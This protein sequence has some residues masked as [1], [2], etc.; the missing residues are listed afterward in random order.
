VGLLQARCRLLA[1]TFGVLAR[2]L[3]GAAG[4]SSRTA[5]G[6]CP[7]RRARALAQH[8]TPRHRSDGH[9]RRSLEDASMA[10]SDFNRLDQASALRKASFARRLGKGQIRS[11]SIERKFPGQGC[12]GTQTKS[13]AALARLESVSRNCAVLASLRGRRRTFL[14]VG[15][16]PVGGGRRTSAFRP[17][18]NIRFW[19]NT[20]EP[21]PAEIAVNRARGVAASA[22][23]ASKAVVPLPANFGR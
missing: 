1:C 7:P 23:F 15:T 5:R 17:Q 13:L 11:M 20:V 2:G 4:I 10:N 19:R 21:A 12:W 22:R 6:P 14:R 18:S 3:L 9:G 16:D 8:S